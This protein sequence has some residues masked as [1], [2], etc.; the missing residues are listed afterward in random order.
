MIPDHLCNDLPRGGTRTNRGT[1]QLKLAKKALLLI[2]GIA[3]VALPFVTGILQGPMLRAQSQSAKNRQHA[4][5]EVASVKPNKAGD[6]RG[7]RG[8]DFLPGGGLTA[9]NL[10]LYALI[11]TAY[12]LP[13]QSSR[14]SGG[15]DWTRSEAFDIEARASQDAIPPGSTVKAREEKTRLMLQT[16]LAERFKLVLRV[17]KKELPVYMATVG[18]NGPKLEKSKIEEKDCPEHGDSANDVN[19]CHI[20]NGGM[21]R[22]LHGAAVDMSDLVLFVANWTDRPVIDR[23]GIKGLFNIQSEGW[24]PIIPRQPSPDGTVS[25]EAEAL[26]DSVRPTLFM[27]FDRLGLKL[28]SSRAP[29]DMYVIVSAEKPAEN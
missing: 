23:T 16:L 9:K 11:A 10:S 1:Q 19:R 4:A 28:E 17:D 3:T 25:P 21:G 15:A 22:G 27:I 12:D 6:P 8:F 24:T 7:Q 13:F 26:S 2:A 29:I 18:R 20:F 5:F 14:V